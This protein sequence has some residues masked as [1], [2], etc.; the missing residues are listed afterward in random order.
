MTEQSATLQTP[1]ADDRRDRTWYVDKA[2]AAVV[3]VGGIS[4]IVFILGIFVFI[5]SQGLTFIFAKLDIGEF[6]TSIALRP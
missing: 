6:F 3:F 5:G 1:A 2:V 4:A